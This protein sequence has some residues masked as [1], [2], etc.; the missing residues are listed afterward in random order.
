MKTFLRTYN[1]YVDDTTGEPRSVKKVGTDRCLRF[2]R[3]LKDCLTELGHDV[4][5]QVYSPLIPDEDHGANFTIYGH[6]S[7]RERPEGNLFHKEMHLPGLFTLDSW[8]WGA[9][10]S[11]MRSAPPFRE[12]DGSTAAAFS[13]RMSGEFLSTGES[14]TLQ[15]ELVGRA[16]HEDFVLVPL[17]VPTDYVIR[18]HSAVSVLEFLETLADWADRCRRLLVIKPHPTRRADTEVLDS[19]AALEATSPW[20]RRGSGNIHELIAAAKG[21]FVINSGVGFESLIH[22][23]PVVSF[24][25]CDYKWATYAGRLDDLDQALDYVD[26]FALEQQL[27]GY[28]LVHYYYWTHGYSVRP[29]AIDDSGRR[30]HDYLAAHLTEAVAATT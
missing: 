7:K 2:E 1:P 25:A 4:M 17:Q 12:V 24:G 8:G 11:A 9:D 30:L 19:L 18:H 5:E 14:R 22:G 27:D 6:L 15:P 26:S 10:H 23:R 29:D 21:V 16:I 28:K 20:V 3:L 13:R